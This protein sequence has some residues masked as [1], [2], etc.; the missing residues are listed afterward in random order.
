[1]S[2]WC[3]SSQYGEWVGNIQGCLLFMSVPVPVVSV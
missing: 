1:M 2:V 3:N